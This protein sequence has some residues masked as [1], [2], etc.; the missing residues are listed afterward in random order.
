M[1][2]PDARLQFV[3][4][5]LGLTPEAGS[6]WLLPRIV[7]M[8]RAAELLLTGRR[9]SGAEAV[10]MGLASEAVPASEV[11]GRAQDLAAEIAKHTAPHAVAATKH[12]L[13]E[14]AMEPDF[15]T[16]FV[17]E[18]RFLLWAASQPDITEALTARIEKR[19][20][21]FSGSKHIELPE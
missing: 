18:A 4:T 20:P 1:V 6:T 3:F 19:S 14:H 12:L 11:L 8:T 7:G 21:R 2:A 16:A 5:R 15:K 9:F 10:A 13:Y 17:R